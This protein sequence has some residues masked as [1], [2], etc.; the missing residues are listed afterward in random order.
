[1]PSTPNHV[2]QIEVVYR[3]NTS[4]VRLDNRESLDPV[5][6]MRAFRSHIQNMLGTCRLIAPN[7]DVITTVVRD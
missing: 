1:M 5:G 7:G 2:Y 4:T 3:G 6:A